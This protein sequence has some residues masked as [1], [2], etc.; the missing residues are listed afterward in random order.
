V[1]VSPPSTPLGEGAATGGA[2]ERIGLYG[3]TFDPVHH[4]HLI[5]AREVRERLALDRVVFIPAARSPF[6]PGVETSPAALRLEM[7]EAAVAAEEGLE[8]D[9]QEIRRGG[10]SYTIDT[11]EA[12]R[13]RF[14]DATL[15]W[16]VG[17]DHAGELGRWRQSSELRRLVRFV[18]LSRDAPAA[19]GFDGE[20][21][22]RPVSISATEVRARVAQ[23][24]SIRYLVPESV[25]AL[26]IKHGLYRT[27]CQT[28][29]PSTRIP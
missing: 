8:V 4:G 29:Q 7:I 21:V 18:V 17:Q 6:K 22:H 20:A 11:V 2:G 19:P 27:A 10:V 13:G 23:G 26:I 9:D 12:W 1:I 3:G 16:L 15:F 24:R 25:R 28:L 5:L 14:P